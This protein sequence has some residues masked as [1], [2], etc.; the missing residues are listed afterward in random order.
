MVTC[1][2]DLE[3]KTSNEQMSIGSPIM[4]KKSRAK[5]APAQERAGSRSD[6]SLEGMRRTFREHILSCR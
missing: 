3:F 2:S 6:L 5:Q 4:V 1:H